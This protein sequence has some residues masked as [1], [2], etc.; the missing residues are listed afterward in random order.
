MLFGY[1]GPETMMPLASVVAAVVGIFLMFGRNVMYIARGVV[2]KVRASGS[3]GS[4][5][6]PAGTLSLDV[7]FLVVFAANHQK[8]QEGFSIEESS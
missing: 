3:Q 8:T 1:V 2:R 5:F 7:A 6:R 4:R